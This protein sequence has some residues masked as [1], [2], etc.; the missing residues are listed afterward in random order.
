MTA[1]NGPLHRLESWVSTLQ[2]LVDGAIIIIAQVLAHAVYVEPWRDQTTT[3]TVIALLVFGLAAEVGGLYRPWRTVTILRE[4]EDALLS[5]ISVPLVLFAF[6]FLTKTATHYSRVTSFTWFVLA[7]LLLC[8]VRVGVRS[9]LRILRARGRNSRRVA[10]LGCTVDAER[11]AEALEVRPW[12]G[13]V[14]S[15]VYDDRSEDRRYVPEHPR[16]SVVGTS[17]DLARACHQGKLDVVYVALP[18]RAE[19]RTAEILADLADTTV[20]VYL[21][22]DLLYYSLLSAQ[23][24]QV[25]DVPLVSLHDSPFQGIV[26]WVKRL[27]D[28]VLGSFIVL[29]TT[30]P[31][32]CIAVAIKMKS[33]GPIFFR[34]SRYGL[35]G[36]SIRILKFRTMTV[37]EDGPDIVQVAKDDVRVTKLGKF[38]RRTSLDE[39]PQFLQVITGELSLVGPRPH[40]VAHN[41]KYRA[42]IH[43]YMLRHTVKPGITGWAQVNGWRGETIELEKMEERVRHDMEYIRNW[44]LLLDLKII[45]LTIFGAKKSRNAY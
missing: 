19:V 23:W 27:E 40:A 39:F 12:L 21:V 24:S 33:P 3:I 44:N 22:A 18:L 1:N 41:E 11:L 8:A 37:C 7:P 16:C 4:V 35:C 36:K 2:R 13:L 14:L 30:L 5:W 26:G 28:L 34:Q 6:W 9:I 15:G 31:M 29:L 10:I 43:G 38:L 17:K 32:I 45:F 25:G 20:T 42:L